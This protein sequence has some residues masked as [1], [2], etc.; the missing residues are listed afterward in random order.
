MDEGSGRALAARVTWDSRDDPKF[1]VRGVWAEGLLEHWGF[2]GDF[3]FDWAQGQ[4][5]AFVPIPTTGGLFVSLRVMGGGRLG[6]GDTL[7][8]Q[9]LYRLGAGVRF[10]DTRR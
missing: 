3:E 6:S 9:F 7:A 10:P 8:P 2:G 4:A 1:A 5:R